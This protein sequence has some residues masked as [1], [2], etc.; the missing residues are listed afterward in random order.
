MKNNN[1]LDFL[2]LVAIVLLA[3]G[4]KSYIFPN[5]KNQ[6]NNTK[7]TGSAF[8]QQSGSSSITD[9]I[10]NS[11]TINT[12]N[13]TNAINV[14]NAAVINPSI[15]YL[16]LFKKF[17]NYAY[18]LDKS[19]VYYKSYDIDKLRGFSDYNSGDYLEV[20]ADSYINLPFK[21]KYYNVAKKNYI[22]VSKLINNITSVKISTNGYV[23]V[24]PIDN[25]I[26]NSDIEQAIIANNSTQ[27]NPV[28]KV[29]SSQYDF[30]S[31]RGSLI[32]N[33]TAKGDLNGD[34]LEDAIVQETWCSASCGAVFTFI[35]N[36]KNTS[37]QRPIR[38][39]DLTPPG[40]VLTGYKQATIRSV[41]INKGVISISANDGT[42]NFTNKY[43]L[44]LAGTS[45]YYL[46]KI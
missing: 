26:T 14:A 33:Y 19:G 18:L 24:T 34:G 29:S 25:S 9:S 41:T 20:I 44:K 5:S 3:F 36:L 23:N 16:R 30:L 32:V 10:N 17:D 22:Y 6:S 8:I 7:N 43:K 37:S 1:S 38:V 27:G 31:G 46:Q 45:T 28:R 40:I 21:E 13:A 2:L 4:A 11:N 42:K 39:F 35:V 12:A 15:K